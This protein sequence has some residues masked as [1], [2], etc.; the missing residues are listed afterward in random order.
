VYYFLFAKFRSLFQSIFD[1]GEKPLKPETW[2]FPQKIS[3]IDLLGCW[4]TRCWS[5]SL[6]L[7]TMKNYFN[8]EED[9]IAELAAGQLLGKF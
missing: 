4:L 7:S 1:T 9:E 5:R 8:E 3:L 2:L 6:P